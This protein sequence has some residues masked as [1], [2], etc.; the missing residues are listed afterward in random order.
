MKTLLIFILL[1]FIYFFFLIFWIFHFWFHFRYGFLQNV[2][3]ISFLNHFSN[4]HLSW[5]SHSIISICYLGLE[6]VVCC[7]LWFNL[8]VYTLTRSLYFLNSLSMFLIVL[9]NSV[10]WYPCKMFFL[11]ATVIGLMALMDYFSFSNKSC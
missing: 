7:I 4:P 8:G 1:K 2:Y 11:G 10:S 5:L 3:L 9:L 6:W